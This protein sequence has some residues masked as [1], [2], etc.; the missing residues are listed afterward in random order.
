ME[1]AATGGI[2][3][4]RGFDYQATV[5]LDCLITHFEEYGSK[6]SVRPE[7]IDDL[8]LNWTGEDGA[9]FQRYIQIKKPREDQYFNLTSK[10]WTVAEVSAQLI[11]GAL[12]KQNY[13]DAE[14]VWI[15]GDEVEQ[16]VTD[17]IT[18]GSK[19]PEKAT[20]AYWQV[21]HS[22]TREVAIKGA[23]IEKQIRQRFMRWKL[24]SNLSED[25]KLALAHLIEAFTA[26]MLEIG[27][28]TSVVEKYTET[29]QQKTTEL[30]SVLERVTINAAF[31]TENDV[32]HRVRE[33]IKNRYKIDETVIETTLFRNLRGFINDI[34]KQPDRHFDQNEFELELRAVWPMMIP[35]KDPPPLDQDHIF[36]PDLT[37]PFISEW[38]GKVIETIGVSG[39]G[40]TM[41][42][43]EI[44]K[45]SCDLD[46]NRHVVYAEVRT[47]TDLRDV[48]SGFAFHLRRLGFLGLFKIAIDQK[49]SNEAVIADM[50]RALSVVPEDTL[51][52][53]DLVQGTCSDTFARDLAAFLRADNLGGVGSRYWVKKVLYATSTLLIA[54]SFRLKA[55][56]FVASI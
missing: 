3:A 32:T 38:T 31:G 54:S 46:P 47:N 5:I 22:L 24:P 4:L 33:R 37:I 19:A 35:I 41:L 20:T 53:I 2:V 18:A 25:T 15:L 13:Q 56:I 30:P 28:D 16:D 40:K 36:R 21:V 45:S 8:V 34:S 42:A 49:A 48:L 51:L 12:A 10:K 50:A 43:A 9:S 44:C 6:A 27:L 11:P 39:A 14:Q 1:K 17:L 55:L 23:S 7:G 26:F 29:I 52:V